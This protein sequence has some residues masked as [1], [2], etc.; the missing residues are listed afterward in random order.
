M[1]FDFVQLIGVSKFSMQEQITQWR[2]DTNAID[3]GTFYFHD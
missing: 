3:E 2:R 1:F